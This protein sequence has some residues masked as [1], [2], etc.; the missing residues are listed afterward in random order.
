[1]NTGD[2]WWATQ[3]Q[4]PAGLTIVSV[5]C[6]SDKTNRTNILGDQP[7]WPLYLTIGNIR[8]EIHRTLITHTWNLVGLIPCR[9]KGAKNT[10]EV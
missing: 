1:M 6:A 9:P 4:L 5:I 7:A 2:W 8:K 3:D 10:D